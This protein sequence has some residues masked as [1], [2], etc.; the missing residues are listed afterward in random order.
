MSKMGRYLPE[1]YFKSLSGY[2]PSG[3]LNISSKIKGKLSNTSN[4][5][6][7]ASWQL[8]NGRATYNK[9]DVTFKDVSFKG[10]FTNG[11]RNNYESCSI[12]ISDF[13]AKLGS[14]EY[15]GSAVV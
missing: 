15:T 6:I 9:S 11:K 7:E 12:S 10:Q 13:I 4:P 5:H 2:N 3:T 14:S 1:K 8:K